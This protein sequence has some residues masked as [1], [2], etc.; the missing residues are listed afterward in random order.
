MH[1]KCV[2]VR[3]LLN[4]DADGLIAVE[5]EIAGVSLRSKLDA[6][7]ILQLDQASIRRSL[8][9]DVSELLR[10]VHASVSADAYL[11]LLAG[12]RGRLAHRSGRNLHILRPDRVRD[13][14]RR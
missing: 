10:I 5:T 13:I 2:G 14:R 1:I 7:D 3:E 8:H 4:T 11:E 6:C 9:D 12:G